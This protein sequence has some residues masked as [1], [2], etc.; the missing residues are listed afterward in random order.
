MQWLRNTNI[1]TRLIILVTSVIMMM[2]IL[3]FIS[4]SNVNTIND[5]LTVINDLNSLKQ[6]YA[7]NFRGSVHDRSIDIRDVTLV[8]QLE[9]ENVV[10]DIA[11]LKLDYDLSET[12]MNTLMDDPE[13]VDATERRILGDI[14]ATQ[15]ATLPLIDQI[16]EL[17]RTGQI[18]EAKELLLSE[19]RPNFVTWLAQINEFIDYEENKNQSVTEETRNTATGFALLM[20]LS[21]ALSIILGLSLGWWMLAS[22]KPLGGLTRRIA[23]LAEGNLDVAIPNARSTDEVGRILKAVAVFKDNA[24]EQKRLEEEAKA[25]DAEEAKADE[26][27]RQQQESE[28]LERQREREIEQDKQRR[29]RQA[30]MIALA[31]QFE[32]SMRGIVDGVSASATEMEKAAVQLS[33]T[34]EDTRKKSEEVAADAGSAN[35][36]AES[37]AGSARELSN[38]IRDIADQT[39]RS[40]TA[41]TDAVNRTTE[42]STD[43]DQLVGAAEAIGNVVNLINDIA[44]QTNLLA[45]N[46]T[47][48][49]ARAGEAGKGF[50]VVA[51]E[52]KS[53]ASQTSE[54]TRQIDD[55]ISDMQRAT[56]AAAQAIS[57]VR[58]TVNGIGSTSVAIASSVEEQDSSTQEIALN[59]SE[60]S[61]GTQNVR[62]NIE[63]VLAGAID[64]GLAAN[65]M[66][67]SARNLTEKSDELKQ[68]TDA[69]IAQIRSD[70]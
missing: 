30:E 50:A 52:V 15:Q 68:E 1:S 2:V 55:Q 9:V 66:L 65:Q 70:N 32:R 27:R 12:E 36:N 44:E 60:V 23:T 47:I 8:D 11:G 59:V 33:A 5:N 28:R 16:I 10:S 21:T 20:V 69:F 67:M 3:S 35:S 34:A 64:T 57:Q 40:S 63:V 39:A 61:D 22:V 19:A 31:D 62:Q 38:S 24:I 58:D 46:A 29:E 17:R 49:A 25:R 4:V 7:I 43:V 54:A 26:H 56:A 42:A 37:V 14:K 48:E 45:L 51:S 18:E 13:L 6:R 53:L 41:A